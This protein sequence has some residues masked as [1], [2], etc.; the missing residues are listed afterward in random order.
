VSRTRFSHMNCSAAQAL[1][2]IGDWWTL[3]II[4]EAFYGTISFSAFQRTLGISKNVL[5]DR[6]RTLCANGTMRKVAK[7]EGV[8]RHIYLL[9]DKGRDL[10]PVLVALMQWG[11]HWVSGRGSEPVEILDAE[12]RNPIA[13][14][15]V[16][17]EG[18]NEL[19]ARDLSFA[20]G[21]GAGEDLRQRFA[22]AGHS[23]D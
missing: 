21:P 17:G 7:T 11:D 9:T 5:S 14:V 3:L 15:A 19:R 4:R 16:F 8:E 20:P 1:E 2:H 10:L 22:R 18:G 12:T 23:V 6:L 13:R